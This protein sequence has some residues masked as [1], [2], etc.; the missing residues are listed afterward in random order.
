MSKLS[1]LSVNIIY[2]KTN[3]YGLN[4]DVQVI[5]RILRHLQDIVGPINKARTADLREPLT[6]SDINFHLEIPTFSAIP[7]AH[8]NVILVNPTQWS[9]SYDVYAHAFDALVFRDL[10]SAATFRDDFTKKGFP[11]DNIYVVPWAASWQVKDIKKTRAVIA[12]V[13]AGFVCFIAGSTSKYEYIKKLLPVWKKSDPILTIYTTRSDFAE[14]LKKMDV[15]AA[16]DANITIKC[17]DLDTEARNRIMTAARGHIVCSQGDVF[18]YAAANAEVAGAFTIMNSLPVFEETYGVT[19]PAIGWISNTYEVSDKVR[20]TIASPSSQLREELDKAFARFNSADFN[21]TY[22]IRQAAANKRFPITCIEFL[23]VLKRLYSSIKERRPKKGNYIC[24]PIISVD[25]PPI[26][27]IT[28]I[29]PTYNRK[30][31]FEIAFHNILLTDYPKDK[32][33]W[34]VI[35]DNDTMPHLVG[36]STMSFQVQVPDIKIKYIPI[37]GRMTIGEKR[38]LGVENA[39]NDIILFM[40][41]DDH[42]P[43]TSFR[44]R[45]AWLTKGTKRGVIGQANIACCTTLALYDLNRGISAVNVPPY[46]IPFA[47]RISEAT[48]TFRKSAWLERKF[49]NISVAEGEDWISGRE[50]QVIEIPPQQIIVAFSHGANQS[51]RCIPPSD[52][53]PACFWHFPQEYLVFIHGLVGVEVVTKTKA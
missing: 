7:W 46:D 5:E 14:D 11:T 21:E 6:P 28:I 10:A 32:I 39:S 24:P 19:N 4:D 15:V 45:V 31:L 52:Q 20:H 9:Y 44:R 12:T 8:T 22:K 33:E 34:I 50:D 1:P 35:E 40:D 2:N 18:G 3:S 17:E 41:D 26:P 36:E 38:N 30:K 29:T 37:Q 49:S 23:P 47:Q 25:N 42:Y 48:L 43:E 13:T 16:V 53:K 51:V 27:P